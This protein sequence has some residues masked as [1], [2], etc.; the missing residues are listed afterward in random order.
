MNWNQLYTSSTA[1]ERLEVL[2]HMLVVIEARQNKRILARGRLIHERRGPFAGAHFL[3]DRRTSLSIRV[4][5]MGRGRGGV[6]TFFILLTVSITIWLSFFHLPPI[7]AAP[8][9]FFHL[10]SLTALLVIKPYNVR[11]WSPDQAR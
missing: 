11:A 10:A 4:L 7:Y 2:I 1:E 3:N 8:L 9:M 5:R 6:F